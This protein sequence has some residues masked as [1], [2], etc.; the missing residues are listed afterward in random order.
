MKILLVPCW[1][2]L[3]SSLV[4]GQQDIERQIFKGLDACYNFNWEQADQIFKSLI[5]KYP[6]DPRGYHFESSIYLW[7]YLGGK[8]KNDLDTFEVYSDKAIGKGESL[9]GKN[10]NDEMALYILGANYNYRA[11][12]FGKAENFLDAA[13]ASKKSESFLSQ[14]LAINP[15]RTDAYL[16]LGLYN[17]AVAQIP[18]A[19]KWALN[20]VGIS[21]DMETGVKYIENAAENGNYAKVE[22]QYYLAQIEMDFLID[23]ESSGAILKKLVRRFPQNLLFNYSYAVL[24]MKERKLTEANKFLDKVIKTHKLQFSQITSFS[25]FLKGDINYRN[26][27]LDSAKTYYLH[28]LNISEDH[29]YTGIAAYRLAI[30]CEAAGNREEAVTYF[31]KA[32]T[33]NMDLDDDIYAKRKGEIYVKRTLAPAELKLIYIANMIEAGKYK[34]AYDSV[35]SL[36]PIIQAE[37]L[38][39][40][41]L[42]Y[43]SE[44]AYYMGSYQES[45][46]LS[47]QVLTMD[48]SNE[49]WI[50]PYSYY[51]MARANKKLGNQDEVKLDAEKADDNNNFDYQNKL[52]NLI[53][54]LEED[55]LKN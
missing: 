24:L 15:K 28:F 51:F 53:Y 25:Y 10:E 12:A 54:P 55:S 5:E 52:K 35:S 37:K 23:Y 43:K 30:C 9:I 22:A 44:A 34:A 8:D 7:Y 2:I 48:P 39:A 18:A 1:V 6:D 32:Q 36:F 19:F 14:V 50:I 31:E 26:N 29:D 13:W 40:E 3:F 11:I 45:V 33:G 41:A 4:I 49:K 20:L 27:Q 46:D 42:L 47:R 38:K 21:G 17:F 16:G